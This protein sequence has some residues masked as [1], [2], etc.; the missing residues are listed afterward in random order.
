[1]KTTQSIFIKKQDLASEKVRSQNKES[2]KAQQNNVNRMITVFTKI[3]S[4]IK[5]K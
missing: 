1:M 3:L 2:G 4:S 5:K